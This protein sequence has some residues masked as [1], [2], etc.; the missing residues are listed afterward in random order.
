MNIQANVASLLSS[1]LVL[2]LVN[3]SNALADPCIY[4]SDPKGI[5][6]ITSLGRVDGTPMWKN[7]HPN[8]SDDHGKCNFYFIS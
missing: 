2:H 4:D 5:I 3:K 7:I 8:T 6:N 1:F